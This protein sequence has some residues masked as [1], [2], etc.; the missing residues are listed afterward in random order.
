MHRPNHLVPN[1]HPLGL[2]SQ[3]LAWCADL[4]RPSPC[5]PHQPVCCPHSPCSA[6]M[7]SLRTLCLSPRWSWPAL[8]HRQTSRWHHRQKAFLSACAPSWLCAPCA[9]G[10]AAVTESRSAAPP[11]DGESRRAWLECHPRPCRAQPSP[12]RRPVHTVAGMG[13]LSEATSTSSPQWFSGSGAS[14]PGGA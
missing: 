11:L 9:P 4:S 1:L 5:C 12:G 10:S 2:Q 3:A 7:T 8:A 6:S 14:E 13:T